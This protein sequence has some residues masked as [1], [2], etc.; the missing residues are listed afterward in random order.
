MSQIHNLVLSFKVSTLITLTHVLSPVI[1]YM[2]Q[3]NQTWKKEY[4]GRWVALSPATNCHKNSQLT[5]IEIGRLLM[6]LRT[7]PGQVLVAHGLCTNI[8]LS[9]GPC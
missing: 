2:G 9:K 8:G 5:P 7:L 3:R 4:G 6:N 1:T